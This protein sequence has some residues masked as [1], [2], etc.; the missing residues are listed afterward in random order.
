M[1][2][3]PKVAAERALQRYMDGGETGRFVPPE[4]SVESTSNEGSFDGVRDKMD[5][6]EVYDNN[7]SDF[8]PQLHAEGG[9]DFYEKTATEIKDYAPGVKATNDRDEVKA[10]KETWFAKSPIK[11][12]RQIVREAPAAQTALDMV[13]RRVAATVGVPWKNP[14]AKTKSAKGIARTRA[15]IAARKG[16]ASRV[17]D[18]ARGTFVVNNPAQ[19]D[20]LTAELAKNY[21]VTVEDWKLTDV[22]YFD[23]TVNLRMPNGMVAEIQMIDPDMSLAKSSPAQGGGGGHDMYAEAR[24]IDPYESEAARERYDELMG[25]MSALYGGVSSNYSPLWASEFERQAREFAVLSFRP[26]KRRS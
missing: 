1:F 4:Y 10:A 25:G 2:A 12:I 9:K 3:S 26:P 6:W 23:R 18:V 7:E 5:F 11:D 15:K 8:N 22:N 21:E 20:Q 19:V 17:T 13:A 24:V 16:D 14:G